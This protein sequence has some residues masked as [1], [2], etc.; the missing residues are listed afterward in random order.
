M[1]L[2]L[3]QEEFGG[4]L[5]LFVPK[6]A[7]GQQ[8]TLV[9]RLADNSVRVAAGS[10]TISGK[11]RFGE[12]G[13]G[14]DEPLQIKVQPTD[15]TLVDDLGTAQTVHVPAVSLVLSGIGTVNDQNV[16][17][18]KN[19]TVTATVGTANAPLLATEISADATL[20][21]AVSASRIE[22]TKCDGDL[23]GLQSAFGPL[24]PLVMP[25]ASAGAGAA[26]KPSV[27]QMVAQNLLVCTSGKLSGSMLASYDGTT[28]TIQ[29]PFT[30]SIAN[31]TV[32][33]RGGGRP[34]RRSTIKRWRWPSADRRPRSG[35]TA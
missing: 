3:L 13:F 6:P 11:G 34:R 22:L 24:L 19:L 18:I 27:L 1:D 12:S 23:P 9:Q 31:L 33:Q 10:V 8:P 35:F 15:L 32:E 25:Q 7:D 21:Q 30:A 14:F 20:G 29:K 28:L 16:T 5:S 4:A 26:T 2:R 17:S